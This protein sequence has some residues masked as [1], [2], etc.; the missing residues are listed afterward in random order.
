M[1]ADL[2]RRPRTRP[3]RFLWLFSYDYVHSQRGRPWPD[4]LDFTAALI[5][6]AVALRG[7]VGRRSRCRGLRRA[8]AVGLSAV[9]AVVFTLF[10]L[11]GYM[12]ASRRLW[13]QKGPIADLLPRAPRPPRSDWSPTSSTG[14]ARPSTRRTR[15]TRA[16]PRSARCSI[17]TAPTTSCKEWLG[18]PPRPARL[19]PLRALQQARCQALLPAGGAGELPG[20]RRAEQQVLPRRGASSDGARDDD[21]RLPPVGPASSRRAASFRR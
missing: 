4:K 8:G 13:S 3:Q 1:T 20:R 11:D 12:P 10:L 2:A 14:A 15:S 9:A 5:A 19:L 21:S 7:A 18:A 6:F 17:R 16:R